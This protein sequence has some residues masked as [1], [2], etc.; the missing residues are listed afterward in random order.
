MSEP[1]KTGIFFPTTLSNQVCLN[2]KHSNNKLLGICVDAN[3]KE[4]H[5]FFCDECLFDL[6]NGHKILKIKAVDEF[7]NKEINKHKD[8]S[9]SLLAEHMKKYEKII[10]IPNDPEDLML[11]VMEFS[12]NSDK[13]SW[14]ACARK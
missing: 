1:S 13:L 9:D 4:E 8:F 2:P 12:S 7:L 6:H 14:L 3:C 10:N 11:Y 5:K